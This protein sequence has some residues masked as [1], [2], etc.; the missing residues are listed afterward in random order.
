MFCGS[1]SLGRRCEFFNTIRSKQLLGIFCQLA[2]T[3]FGADYSI[4]R[5]GLRRDECVSHAISYR[6]TASGI[7]ALRILRGR[8]DPGPHLMLTQ[9]S[10]WHV[11]A[12]SSPLLNV[13]PTCKIY[14]RFEMDTAFS[15]KTLSPDKDIK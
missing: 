4:V 12:R 11:K 15:H 8:I 2:N 1:G 5:S 10:I 3:S 6:T 14:M 9:A 13:V 7:L